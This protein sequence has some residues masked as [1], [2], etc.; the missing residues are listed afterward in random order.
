MIDTPSR[1][2]PS[3]HTSGIDVMILF[4]IL[5]LINC[6]VPND[7]LFDYRFDLG[8]FPVNALD[9]MLMLVFVQQLFSSSR[10]RFQ[11]E[12]AHPLLYWSIGLLVTARVCAIAA[13]AIHYVIAN[14][15]TSKNNASNG[16]VLI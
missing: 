7:V 16:R 14:T 15:P 2:N 5:M 13:A 3:T 4:V 12:R 6:T 10:D 1:G 9:V 11:T 8:G